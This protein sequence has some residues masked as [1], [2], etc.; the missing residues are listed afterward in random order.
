MLKSFLI[1]LLV[2][3]C[4]L[5]WAGNRNI[6]KEYYQSGEL[7]AVYTKISKKAFQVAYYYRN[8]QV[9]ETGF[10]KDGKNHGLWISYA[11]DGRKLMEAKFFGNERLGKW[12]Y[13]DRQGSLQN[14]VSFKNDTAIEYAV[15]DEAGNLIA[16]AP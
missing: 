7:A 1:I 11:E 2:A 8:G 4:S 3:S 6:E 9:R 10:V 16:Y 15:R 14:T 5:S 12:Y 13:W